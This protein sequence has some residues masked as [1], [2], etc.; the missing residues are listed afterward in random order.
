VVESCDFVKDATET[1]Y[2]RFLIIGLFLAYLRR[3]VVW[4][5]NGSIS[6]VIGMLEHS[7]D[8]E[9]SNFNVAFGSQEDILSL[10]VPM[11]NLFIVYVVHSEGHLDKPC[12]NLVL[13]EECSQLFLFSYFVKHVPSLAIIHHYA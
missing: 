9:I 5:S 3:K 1:P 2:I 6:T 10:K 8:A 12:D 4:R 13:R 11:E 7:G